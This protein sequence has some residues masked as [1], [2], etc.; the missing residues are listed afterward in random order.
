M[1]G[2]KHQPA[3]ARGGEGG[4]GGV[5]DRKAK[6]CV[7]MYTEA[8]PWL[9]SSSP[10]FRVLIQPGT[11]GG[12]PGLGRRFET[13]RGLKSEQNII[14]SWLKEKA[15]VEPPAAVVPWLHA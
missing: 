8:L 4:L 14:R 7:T 12:V 13:D 15:W 11:K 1:K 10:S 6:F 3:P 5:A 2:V 9:G